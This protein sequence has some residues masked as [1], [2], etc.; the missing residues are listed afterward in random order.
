VGGDATAQAGGEDADI[1]EDEGPEDPVKE[2]KEVQRH[3][4]MAQVKHEDSKTDQS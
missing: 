2:K 4:R 1:D 3:D